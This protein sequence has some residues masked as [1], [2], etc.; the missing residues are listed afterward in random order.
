MFLVEAILILI[1]IFLF[2]VF[3]NYP[4]TNRI[5]QTTNQNSPAP[6]EISAE[7]FQT[8]YTT[9][10]VIIKNIEKVNWKNCEGKINNKYSYKIDNIPVTPDGNSVQTISASDFML[11][12]G[13]EFDAMSEGIDVIC[14]I[15]QNPRY[16]SSCVKRG[17]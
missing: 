14:V 1:I 12:L 7:I 10:V 4:E 3:F 8:G 17:K 6:F 11:S 9:P 5:D 2:F 15:C 16:L 13:Q